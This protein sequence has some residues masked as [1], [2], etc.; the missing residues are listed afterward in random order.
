MAGSP[1]HPGAAIWGGLPF[2]SAR[3]PVST[4]WPAAPVPHAAGAELGVVVI[5]GIC[6]VTGS[7]FGR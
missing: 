1:D 4:E 7:C 3:P 6:A 2:P 5:L